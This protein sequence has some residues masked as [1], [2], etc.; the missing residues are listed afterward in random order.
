MLSKSIGLQ[1]YKLRV[2]EEIGSAYQAAFP[3]RYEAALQMVREAR[4]ILIRPSGMSSNGNMRWS[5]RV[6]AEV[7]LCI[8]RYLPD[9]GEDD[10][11]WD[12]LLRAWPALKV[13]T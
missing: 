12:L 8:R 6:P 9:F 11:D 7:F 2:L 13:G 10:A 5:M 1:A 3:E 4:E